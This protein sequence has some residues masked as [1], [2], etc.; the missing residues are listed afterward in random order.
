MKPYLLDYVES[1]G[2]TVATGGK[3][4]LENLSSTVGCVKT[5]RLSAVYTFFA[6]NWHLVT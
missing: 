4:R 5:Y 1:F 2:P 6:E 3:Y